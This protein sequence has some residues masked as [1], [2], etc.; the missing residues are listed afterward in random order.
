MIRK[1]LAK[2]SK[3]HCNSRFITQFKSAASK[4]YER[5]TLLPNIDHCGC[6][7]RVV[8]ARFLISSIPKHV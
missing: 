6:S 2:A 1:H 4:V 3:F 8:C 5:V 7:T